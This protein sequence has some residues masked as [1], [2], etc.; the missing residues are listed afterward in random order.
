M[1]KTNCKKISAALAAT[2]LCMS[3]FA[4]TDNVNNDVAD[5]SQTA[6]I[7]AT[8]VSAGETASPENTSA[9]A[10]A[11][12]VATD[13][14]TAEPTPVPTAT[15]TAEPTPIPTATPMPQPTADPAVYPD[16]WGVGK[17]YGDDDTWSGLKIYRTDGETAIIW[18]KTNHFV[19]IPDSLP[20]T[21]YV[22][23]ADEKNE[24]MFISVGTMKD[25]TLQY[26]ALVNGQFYKLS[27]GKI[28]SMSTDGLNRWAWVEEDGT[29]YSVW[30]RSSSFDEVY[31][32]NTECKEVAYT[33]GKILCMKITEEI[34][35]A[36]D[37]D[38]L[39][40]PIKL[41]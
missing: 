13:P 10:P 18:D 9:P 31:V 19:K 3:L 15:P 29:V 36:I 41:S 23:S 8:P 26:Y 14:P 20:K 25:G 11:T 21:W 24:Q 2:M 22:E 39:R 12:S 17:G 1:K 34:V 6:A 30:V 5:T 40:E 32:E 28:I 7:T 37:E 38:I 27:Q 16:D 35:D 4:C 33:S